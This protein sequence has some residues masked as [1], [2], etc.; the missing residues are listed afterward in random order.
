MHLYL[1]HKSIYLYLLIRYTGRTYTHVIR[2]RIHY[3][4]TIYTIYMYKFFHWA[5][6]LFSTTLLPL[7]PLYYPLFILPFLFVPFLYDPYLTLF[8]LY[9]HMILTFIR[10]SIRTSVQWNSHPMVLWRGRRKMSYTI[11]TRIMIR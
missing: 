9:F 6:S 8:L 4:H 7:L 5:S 11:M 10:T 2:T 3:I 1:C